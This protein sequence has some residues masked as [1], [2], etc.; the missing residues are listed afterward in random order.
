MG[1]E[2]FVNKS[3]GEWNSMRSGHSLAFKQFEE[4]LSHIS[5]TLLQ[6]DDTQ[7]KDYLKESE[8]SKP[9]II[10]PFKI[11]WSGESNW[12][13]SDSSN[14]LSGCSLLIP[15]PSSKQEGIILRSMGYTEKIDAISNYHFISDGTIVLS[16]VYEQTVAEERIW[17]ISENVRCRSSV[18]LSLESKA[19]LQTSFASEIKRVHKPYRE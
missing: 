7:I 14:D 2:E 5:I 4:V 17:F 9:Q 3:E 12:K 6:P 18:I 10:S 19:I 11:E 15:I 1:I 13:G 16:T 8:Y